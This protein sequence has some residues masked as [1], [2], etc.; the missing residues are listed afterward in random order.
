MERPDKV[1]LV[2]SDAMQSHALDRRLK[3]LIEREHI[4]VEIERGVPNAGLNSIQGYAVSLTAEIRRTHPGAEIFLNATG[5]TKLMSLGFVEVFRGVARNILYTDTSHRRIEIFPDISGAAAPSIEMT[6]VLDV[7]T[8]LEAQGFRYLRA[9]SDD[10]SWR[11]R[12]ASRQGTCAYIGKQAVKLQFFIG[13][14]NRLAANALEKPENS[15][16]EILAAPA[17]F[18][19]RVP[20]RDWAGAVREIGRAGLARW[21]EGD[22]KIEFS[23]SESALFL[24]GG[25]LE[26]YAWQIVK[27]EGLHDVRC[28]VEVAGED[29]E[30]VCNEFDLLACNGNEL[31]FIECKTLRYRDENDNQIAY[32]IDSLGQQVRG[33]FGETWLLSAREPTDTL[34]E[35]ARRARIRIIGPADLPGLHSAVKDWMRR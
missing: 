11:N 14:I 29:A 25:W 20:V 6:N 23:D 24:R 19:S 34:F 9:R 1:Y 35:R 27:Q 8:Y 30:D 28:G 21:N 17:Q 5:G 4:E 26:E 18:F 33:L 2:C 31:L 16:D 10:P 7:P 32:K 15:R 22:R 3:R 13:T 12:V